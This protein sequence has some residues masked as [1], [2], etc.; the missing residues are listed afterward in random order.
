MT[1]DFAF[2]V[3]E[4]V[5]AE[6]VL[7]AIRAVDKTLITAARLFDVYTGK[8]VEDGHKSLAISVTLQPTDRTL[9]DAEIDAIAGKIVAA[10]E[11]A[12]GAKLRG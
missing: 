12:T 3:A 10:V 8:G 6:A 11:K 7:K 9:T 1:R 5:E 2:V 4:T